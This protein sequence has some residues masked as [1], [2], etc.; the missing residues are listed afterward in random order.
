LLHEV[1]KSRFGAERYGNDQFIFHLSSNSPMKNAA[2]ATPLV[3]CSI[4]FALGSALS[5]TNANTVIRTIPRSP[6][7][8]K[9]TDGNEVTAWQI[10]WK[11][12][13]SAFANRDASMR[14][15]P[16]GMRMRIWINSGHTFFFC[17]TTIIFQSTF[18]APPMRQR[19][20][21]AMKRRLENLRPMSSMLAP[22]KITGRLSVRARSRVKSSGRVSFVILGLGSLFMW[23]VLYKLPAEGA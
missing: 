11:L 23:G 5:R 2:C 1:I 20:A 15:K 21:P 7:A 12:S 9:I 3:S 16:E 18:P 19:R 17:R 14:R 6:A 22:K 4:Q 8:K 10:V 13:L